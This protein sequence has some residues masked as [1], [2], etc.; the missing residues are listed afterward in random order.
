[1]TVHPASSAG[2]TL[3]L[4]R[5]IGAFHGMIAPTTP[6][7]SRTSSPNCPAAGLTGSSNGYVAA[8]AANALKV[9]CAPRPPYWATACRTP[10]SRGQICP[11]SSDRLLSSAPIASRESA[12]CAC[13]SSRRGAVVE[14]V[15]G[16]LDPVRDLR[17]L[18]LGDGEVDLLG[19][20]VDDAD[21]GVG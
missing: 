12:R 4:I 14:R 5:P 18:R 13:R 10:D 17:R 21:R 8:S 7:G 6:T 2:A 16:R 9:A 20:R 11:S 1:M 19:V 15:P 3:L